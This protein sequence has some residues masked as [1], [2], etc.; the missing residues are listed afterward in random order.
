MLRQTPSRPSGLP[1][2]AWYTTVHLLQAAADLQLKRLHRHGL[3]PL[4]GNALSQL[5]LTPHRSRA[6]FETAGSEN[7][8]TGGFASPKIIA[9]GVPRNAGENK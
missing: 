8:A 1:A 9:R 6:E 4:R 3:K 5:G 2:L 7:H